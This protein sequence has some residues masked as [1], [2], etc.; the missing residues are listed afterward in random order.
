MSHQESL[1]EFVAELVRVSVLGRALEN[2]TAC[3]SRARRAAMWMGENL[4]RRISLSDIA[5]FVG[6]SAYHFLRTFRTHFGITPHAYLTWLRLERGRECLVDGL[7]A[8][9]VATEMGFSDQSHF[10]RAF[11]RAFGYTPVSLQRASG[12]RERPRR[13]AMR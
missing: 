12:G 4:G 8:A 7:P 10:T 6:L 13:G 1:T 11:R 2:T 5:D 3:E 9:Q